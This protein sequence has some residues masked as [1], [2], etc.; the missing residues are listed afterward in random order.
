MVA[1]I[2]G[3]LRPEL[4]S[5]TGE[6]MGKIPNLP[7]V[8]VLPWRFHAGRAKAGAIR[9]A[10]PFESKRGGGWLARP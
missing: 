4:A 5:T 8:A 9:P 3:G 10:P 2:E 7:I 6:T 1:A